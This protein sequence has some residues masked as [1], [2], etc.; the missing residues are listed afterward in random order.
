MGKRGLLASHIV[1]Y[2]CCPHIAV[3]EAFVP[4]LLCLECCCTGHAFCVPRRLSKAASNLV[5]QS[6][7]TEFPLKPDIVFEISPYV[8]PNGS[9]MSF[10]L[11]GLPRSL[12]PTRCR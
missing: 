2:S 7:A 9:V 4:H 8:A 5:A 12:K 1:P 11:C 6:I 10:E 3:L